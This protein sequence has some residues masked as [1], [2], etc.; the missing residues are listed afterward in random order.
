MFHLTSYCNLTHADFSHSLLQTSGL[1]TK[2]ASK[3]PQFPDHL[4]S[5]SAA[6][7][8][9]SP[10][11]TAKS[12]LPSAEDAGQSRQSAVR[13][14]HERELRMV[15]ATSKA[16]VW[17]AD[18]LA[19][20]AEIKAGQARLKYAEKKYLSALDDIRSPSPSSSEGEP[21][22]KRAKTAKARATKAKG[23]AKAKAKA[24]ASNVEDAQSANRD[25][26]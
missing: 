12:P 26:A 11:D 3:R 17:R 4:K 6:A 15:N 16:S 10:L 7:A 8:T 2:A 18:M 1:G 24:Q 5:A 9:G 23:K 20:Q 14:N 19:A 21:R 22:A 25:A 13:R